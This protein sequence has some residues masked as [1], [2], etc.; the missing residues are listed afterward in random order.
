M[1]IAMT[2]FCRSIN[3]QKLNF[4]IFSSGIDLYPNISKKIKIEN[5][6]QTLLHFNSLSIFILKYSF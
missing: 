3:F 5:F 2:D 4:L 6:S 1:K